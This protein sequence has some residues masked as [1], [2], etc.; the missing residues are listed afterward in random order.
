MSQKVPNNRLEKP[1]LSNPTSKSRTNLIKEGERL[2]AV[3]LS[4]DKLSD[5]RKGDEMG[6]ATGRSLQKNTSM[7][8]RPL[9]VFSAMGHPVLWTKE[10]ILQK[11]GASNYVSQPVT[12][13]FISS[14]SAGFN[15]NFTHQSHKIQLNDTNNNRNELTYSQQKLTLS[16][17]MSPAHS[18]SINKIQETHRSSEQ[19]SNISTT[20]KGKSQLPNQ[21]LVSQ[22]VSSPTPGEALITK[23]S[24][25][26]IMSVFSNNKIE[27]SSTLQQL[28]N[29]IGHPL[30]GPILTELTMHYIF[31]LILLYIAWTTTWVPDIRFYLGVSFF[32]FS[33]ITLNIT[34]LIFIRFPNSSMP[35]YLSFLL[36][37]MLIFISREAHQLMQMFWLNS[38]LFI[39]LQSGHPNLNRQLINFSVLF[40]I[41]YVSMLAVMNATYKKDCADLFCGVQL[42]QSISPSQEAVFVVNCWFV[43]A[44]FF[45]LEKFIKINAI[46]LLDR[47]TYMQ[48]LYIANMDLKRQLRSAK[49][50]N[51]VDLEAPLAR[52]TQILKE[53]QET[54]GMDPDVV[55]EIDF[56]IELLSSDKLFQPD[57]FQNTNDADVHDWLKDMLLTDKSEGVQNVAGEVLKIQLPNQAEFSASA[58]FIASDAVLQN[59]DT[60]AFEALKTYTDPSFDVFKLEIITSGHALYYMGWHIFRQ[61]GF[62]EKLRIPEDKFRKWLAMAESGYRRSNAYHNS[63]HAADVTHTM[64]YFITRAKIW[65][66][67]KIEEQYACLIAPIMHDF[68]HPGVN[69]AFL[70][71]TSNA[72][73]LRYNDTSVLEHFHCSSLFE[74]ASNEETNIFEHLSSEQKKYSRELI[75]SM[76]MATDMSQHFEWIGKFKGKINGAGINLEN[77]ADKKLLL[78]FAIKCSDVNNPT[79]PQQQSR[80]WTQLIM[81]EFFAQGD[82]EKERGLPISTFMNRETT[83]VPKCQIVS[84]YS[85]HATVNCE[86]NLCN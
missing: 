26:I 70:V 1:L 16:N 86:T 45:Q 22:N 23:D 79:K 34:R 6:N 24:Q 63:S 8:S 77:K 81:E 35:F 50:D 76:I 62:A 65:S 7:T 33:A 53:V 40:T 75:I 60:E 74:M 21:Y 11:H 12:D 30:R 85:C 20:S 4:R 32:C 73:A 46:T 36:L 56:I 19:R 52:A 71:A 42:Q 2:D 28:L 82:A 44:T 31:F 55:E 14:P 9:N 61:H 67:L 3:R 39:F 37:G 15:S 47:E 57:L 5:L 64:N 78:N 17:K 68:M 49:N 59:F 69:N 84:I 41:V 54:E 72:L 48:H 58:H 80:I 27:Q 38:I 10:A 13:G 29:R 43:I 66:S 83:D 51:E 25:S 18:E